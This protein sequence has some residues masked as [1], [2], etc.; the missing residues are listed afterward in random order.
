LLQL[1]KYRSD[2]PVRVSE[3]QT[4]ADSNKDP[5]QAFENGLPLEIA[6]QLLQSVPTLAVTFHGET[7]RPAFNHNVYPVCAN[8]QLWA[9]SIA[10]GEKTVQHELFKHRIRSPSMLL[11]GTHESLRVTSMLDKPPA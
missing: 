1:C 10:G 2:G 3:K 11:H 4:A 5:T 9:H 8:R 7:A 6:L